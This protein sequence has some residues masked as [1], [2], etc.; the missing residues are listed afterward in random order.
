MILFT[1]FVYFFVPETKNK[2]F[3]EIAHEFSP[4]AVLEVEEML[5]EEDEVFADAPNSPSDFQDGAER[6]VVNFNLGETSDHSDTEDVQSNGKESIPMIDKS[7]HSEDD[8][9]WDYGVNIG[10]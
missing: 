10:K 1:L 6:P 3:E 5:D 9:R 7:D 4:G 2:T 8:L